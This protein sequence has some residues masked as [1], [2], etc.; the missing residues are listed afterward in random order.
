MPIAID[1][2]LVMTNISGFQLESFFLLPGLDPS[3]PVLEM[4]LQVSPPISGGVPAT[5]TP[6]PHCSLKRK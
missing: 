4:A 2:K 1:L 6:S 5:I 3:L